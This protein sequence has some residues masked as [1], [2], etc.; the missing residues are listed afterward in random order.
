MLIGGLQYGYKNTKKATSLLLVLRTGLQDDEAS[1]KTGMQPHLANC[2]FKTRRAFPAFA[3]WHPP[4][5][6]Q[7]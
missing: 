6:S 5:T 2:N 7:P 4:L 3:P 1:E